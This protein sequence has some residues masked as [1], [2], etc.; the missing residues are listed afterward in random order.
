MTM[1]TLSKILILLAASAALVSA[2]AGSVMG[3]ENTVPAPV[4]AQSLAAHGQL[5]PTLSAMDPGLRCRY[6]QISFELSCGGVGSYK[7]DDNGCTWTCSTDF[8]IRTT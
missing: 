8:S 4:N 7:C 3:V 2:L 6:C 1:R 5:E